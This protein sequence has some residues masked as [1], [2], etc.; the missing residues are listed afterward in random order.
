MTVRVYRIHETEFIVKWG[1]E[2]ILG[3]GY[4]AQRLELLLCQRGDDA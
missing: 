3:K 2:K 4:F 1:G